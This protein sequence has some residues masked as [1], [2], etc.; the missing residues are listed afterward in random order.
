MNHTHFGYQSVPTH[1]KEALVGKVFRQVAPHY[2]CMNDCM[3]GGLHRLWKRELIRQ[4][5]PL[6]GTHLLDVA[7]GTGDIAFRFLKAAP[8]AQVTICDINPAMLAEGQKRAFDRGILSGVNW[9]CGNAEALPLPS[10]SYDYYTIA[11]GIRNV[12]HIDKAL[13]E[14]HRVLKPGGRFLCLEFSHVSHPFLSKLYDAYSF[15]VIP[16]LGKYIAQDEASYRYLVESIRMFPNQKE[17]AAR[18][19][20]SGFKQVNYTNLTHGVVAIHSGWKV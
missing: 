8:S 11:F 9:L 18:I 17:F 3:S 16:A 14:A 13:A 1:E 12:T 2:D 19:S 7:G 6:P 20:A 4:M 5:R 10:C 15:H